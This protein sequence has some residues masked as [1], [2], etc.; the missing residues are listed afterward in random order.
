MAAE[1]DHRPSEVLQRDLLNPLTVEK[2]IKDGRAPVIIGREPDD[3]EGEQMEHTFCF[4]PGNDTAPAESFRMSFEDASKI[5]KIRDSLQK[6]L[7]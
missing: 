1:F 4:I 5:A 7:H 3:L 6:N 2:L